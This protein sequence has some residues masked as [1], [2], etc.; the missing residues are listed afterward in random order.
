LVLGRGGDGGAI[1][2]GRKGVS[3]NFSKG[4][5]LGGKGKED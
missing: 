3:V 1:R 4:K 2:K 5:V